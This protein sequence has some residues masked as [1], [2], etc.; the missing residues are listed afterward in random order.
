M[1]LIVVLAAIICGVY[2]SR[3]VVDYFLDDA[4]DFVDD[5][6]PIVLPTIED[7]IDF[8]GTPVYMK[9]LSI[10]NP[11]NF[12]R[13][14]LE[15][16]KTNLCMDI[17][18]EDANFTF[19][20]EQAAKEPYIDAQVNVNHPGIGFID[21]AEILTNYIGT[22]LILTGSGFYPVTNKTIYSLTSL[23]LKFEYKWA[24]T[25]IFSSQSI[26]HAMLDIWK[27]VFEPKLLKLTGNEIF[28]RLNEAFVESESSL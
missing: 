9:M 27:P 25:E 7:E 17:N 5:L 16:G 20:Y 3:S 22:K 14:F 11:Q 18:V 24:E 10:I 15:L 23:T 19:K 2:S 28:I 4:W 21:Q 6:N 1:K 13:G 12:T 8:F 26:V